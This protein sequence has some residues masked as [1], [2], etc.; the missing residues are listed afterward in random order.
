MTRLES[1]HVTCVHLHGFGSDHP[2]DSGGLRASLRESIAEAS[3]EVGC[4]WVRRMRER[5]PY[6]KMGKVLSFVVVGV[7][8]VIVVM[9]VFFFFFMLL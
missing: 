6:R 3:G 5:N 7:I 9:W 4:E 1:E 8:T 2:R